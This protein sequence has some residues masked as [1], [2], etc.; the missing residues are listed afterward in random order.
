MHQERATGVA[1]A[2]FVGYGACVGGN[3]SGLRLWCN[4]DPFSYFLGSPTSKLAFV[5][6][7]HM[8]SNVI[9]YSSSRAIL[10]MEIN[11]KILYLDPK[12][13][14]YFKNS[15]KSTFIFNLSAFSQFLLVILAGLQWR[16]EAES[17]YFQLGGVEE[18]NAPP[19]WNHA[20]RH[21]SLAFPFYILLPCTS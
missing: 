20:H 21:R 15:L 13:E 18:K 14:H 10:T 8:L 5:C 1:L 12:K 16:L 7:L 11:D 9:K 2:L 19:C 3:S 17:W 4:L 6:P